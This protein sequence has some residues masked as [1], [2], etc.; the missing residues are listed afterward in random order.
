MTPDQAELI[1]TAYATHVKGQST[2]IETILAHIA[3]ASPELS[4]LIGHGTD[5]L[6]GQTTSAIDHVV[7]KLH[8]PSEIADYVAG[9]GEFLHDRGVQDDHYAI[10]GDALMQGFE[11][12]FSNNLA[13]EIRDAWSDAWLMFSAIMRE[14]AF[15]VAHNPSAERIGIGAPPANAATSAPGGSRA[16]TASIELEAQN[17]D[18]EVANVNEVAQQISG[19]A[20]QT[21]LLAL[22]ARIEAARTGDAG[23]GFAVVANEIKDLAAQSGEATKGI[24]Q[25]A[26]EISDQVRNLLVSL[27]NETQTDPGTSVD[28]QIIALVTGI[29]KIGAISQRID[30]IAS[31]TNMLALN[32]TIEANRAGDKGRGFAVVAGEVKVLASQTSQ[33]TQQINALVEKLN[34][35]AQR[36]AEMVT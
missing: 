32:A 16:D 21:N 12:C 11:Q 5:E 30:G 10:L 33:A 36:M 20:K 34:A 2:F 22:N 19:V 23:K 28:D 1:Q 26:A 13:P 18:D 8:T 9:Y 4:H 31:E 25:A 29:E 27:K 14:A 24:Y 17:L 6:V 15:G 7:E 3:M 35:L